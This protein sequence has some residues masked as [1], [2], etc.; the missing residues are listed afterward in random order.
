MGRGLMAVLVVG[1]PTIALA[2]IA[3]PPTVVVHRPVPQEHVPVLEVGRYA[4]PI[5]GDPK[6]LRD[7]PVDAVLVSEKV[8]VDAYPT[9]LLVRVTLLLRG[10]DE[11]VS[12]LLVG[13]P[14]KELTVRPAAGSLRMLIGT[15]GKSPTPAKQHQHYS[16]SGMPV[17]DLEVRVDGAPV[18]VLREPVHPTPRKLKKKVAV[19]DQISRPSPHWQVWRMAIPAHRDT[20][21]ELTYTQ[22]LHSPSWGY[23][24]GSAIWVPFRYALFTSGVW[25][26][27][28]E[29][30]E[31]VVHLKGLTRDQ[32]PF[33]RPELPS[34]A[35]L[36]WRYENLE[37]TAEEVSFAI[38]MQEKWA[39]GMR[40][41]AAPY[42]LSAVRPHL[43]L[44]DR[45]IR[46]GRIPNADEHDPTADIAD[47]E[48]LIMEVREAARADQPELAKLRHLAR[49]VLFLLRDRVDPMA[50]DCLAW[51]TPPGELLAADAHPGN[52]S[53]W[54]PAGATDLFDHELSFVCA[55]YDER[56]ARRTQLLAGGGGILVIIIIM[57]LGAVWVLR[58]RRARAG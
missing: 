25:P 15:T 18:Q 58:R 53:G 32:I 10:G 21:L 33:T 9:F 55:A 6:P 44:L 27:R 17:E 3:P 57:A 38:E 34:G 36:R 23:G 56:L 8:E 24:Y 5:P 20:R 50:E 52:A 54:I 51:L 12:D 4:D 11:G 29:R 37:A 48:A 22:A 43:R 40:L 45:L 7:A 28:V 19:L 42:E 2:D 31:L 41:G 13:F 35:A 30:V 16:F 49:G 46:F 14:E 1:L 47:L 26:G 39:E